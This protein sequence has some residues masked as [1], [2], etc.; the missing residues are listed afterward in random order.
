M[1][2]ISK[3]TI[4]KLTRYPKYHKILENTYKCSEILENTP[5]ILKQ[6]RTPL[7][8]PNK[9]Q[10]Y[11]ITLKNPNYPKIPKNTPKYWKIP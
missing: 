11:L 7:N 9:P 5:N 10:K 3:N 8:N 4:K 2:K 6:P 1:F